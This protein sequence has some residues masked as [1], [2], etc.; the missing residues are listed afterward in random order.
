[1]SNFY[2]KI[3]IEQRPKKLKSKRKSYSNTLNPKHQTNENSKP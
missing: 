1:M 2:I 3:N